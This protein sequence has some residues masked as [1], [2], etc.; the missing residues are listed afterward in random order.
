MTTPLHNRYTTPE[1][2][3]QKPP[4]PPSTPHQPLASASGELKRELEPY[5]ITPPTSPIKRRR[6]SVAKKEESDE[7]AEEEDAGPTPRKVRGKRAPVGAL[8]LSDE[9][10]SDS[11]E[12]VGSQS[13]PTLKKVRKPR[14]P[15]ASGSGSTA[16]ST[17]RNRKAAPAPSPPPLP[18]AEARLADLGPKVVPPPAG[19]TGKVVVWPSNISVSPVWLCAF[20]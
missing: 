14:T 19:V 10:Y 3:D 15:R 9:D 17:P 4:L 7:E 12:Q 18:G 20:N 1:Q 5:P 13:H 6:R 8:A 2:P 11:E 16:K